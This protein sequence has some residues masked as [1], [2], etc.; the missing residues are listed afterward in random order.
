MFLTC[1]AFTYTIYNKGQIQDFKLAGAHLKKLCRAEEGANILG[2]FRVKNH[3]FTPK[4][5]LVFTITEG[6]GNVVMVV[7]CLLTLLLYYIW[8][9]NVVIVVLRL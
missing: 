3:Y 5:I 2:V 8:C 1:S 6:G 7:V 9:G 4:K